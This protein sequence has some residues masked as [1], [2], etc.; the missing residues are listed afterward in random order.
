MLYFL[1]FYL[2]INALS[3]FLFWYDKQC[4]INGYYRVKE[5]KLLF[6]S[7]VGGSIGAIAGQKLFRHKTRKFRFILPII[8]T[9]HVITIAALLLNH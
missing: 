7:M 4:A 3:F 9:L 2:G 6:V 5:S 8:L 1:S